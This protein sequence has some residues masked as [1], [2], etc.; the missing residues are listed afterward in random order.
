MYAFIKLYEF[1]PRW[2]YVPGELVTQSLA[3]A[4]VGVR[5][6]V[7]TMFRRLSAS[8]SALAQCLSFQRC[9]SGELRCLLTT[10]VLIKQYA[11]PSHI[12]ISTRFS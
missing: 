12:G 1:L 10:L 4:S 3:S 11:N 2:D 7:S 5:V 8:A 6:R 9:A